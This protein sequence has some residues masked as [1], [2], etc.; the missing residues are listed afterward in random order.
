MTEEKLQELLR[1]MTLEEKIG[2]LIQLDGGCYGESELATGPQQKLGIT[3]ATVD[4]SGSVLNV[5]GADKVRA[6]QKRYLERSRLK[7]PLLFMADIIY[8]YKTVYPIPLGLGC[9]WDPE[10]IRQD[11]T[12][13]A[14]EAC[15]DGGMV[16][17]SPPVDLIRD[18]RWGRC[19]ESPGEDPWLNSRYADAMVRGFQNDFIPGHSMA[20]CVKHFAAYGAVEAGREYNTVD[21]SERRLRQDYLPSY[22]AAVQAGCALVMTSFN[23]VDEVPVTA[24]RWLLHDVLRKEWGFDGVIITDYAAIQELKAHGV[25]ADDRQASQ[26]AMDATV[27]IDMKTPCYAKQLAP[28]V[29]DGV[30]DERQ[31]DAACLRILRLKNRLGLFED[32]YRGAD[33]ALAEARAADPAHAVSARQTAQKAMVLLKN[34]GN[35]LPLPKQ[36]KTIALIGPYA[37]SSDVIGMWAIHADKSRA[38]TLRRA[39]EEVLPPDSFGWTPGC[40]TLDDLSGLGEFGNIPALKGTTADDATAARWEQEALDLAR[41][42]DVVVLAMG[43]HMLQSGEG[44]SRTDITLPACQKRLLHKLRAVGKPVVL[45]LFNGRPLALSDVEPDC[46]AILEAWFPG[47]AGARAIVDLLFGDA[48]PEGRLTTSFPRCVGQEPLYYSQFNTGRPVQGSGHSGRFTS[49][50]LDCPNT[51]LYP[52]GYGL[53]YHTARCTD[54]TLSADTLHPGETLTARVTVTNTSDQPGTEVV[55][56]YLRDLVGSVVRPVQELKGFEKVRLQPGESRTVSFPIEEPMLRYYT[57]DMTYQSEPGEFEVMIGLHS[58]AVERAR[59]RLLPQP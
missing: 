1:Q 15:A 6:I 45:V 12:I 11:Y 46:D 44:G 52:F 8:G 17:F 26:L 28:L 22:R 31:I 54:L 16:T 9:T 4:V 20:S 40:R 34:Q 49:R 30:L 56:L 50:Y 53:G 41:R 33:A 42:S 7:I 18:A 23:T 5:L 21:M 3:Q 36:G 29:R 55:Q 10:L 58:G 24:N 35:V 37:D 19:M 47:T 32:P 51:L 27:D 43:E 38:I 14:E 59:F 57:R 13:V 25:A 39:M 48:A 2:Q